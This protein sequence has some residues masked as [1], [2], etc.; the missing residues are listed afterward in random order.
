[1]AITASDWGHSWNPSAR[2]QGFSIDVRV[3]SSVNW[4]KC[5][6]VQGGWR[7][8]QDATGYTV[9][10]TLY[11]SDP[12]P[13][14]RRGDHLPASGQCA[15]SPAFAGY[16][17]SEVEIEPQTSA[18]PWLC[19]VTA[20]PTILS[21]DASGSKRRERSVKLY[22]QNVAVRDAKVLSPDW[23]GMRELPCR[24]SQCTWRRTCST[25]SGVP[26]QHGIVTG[27]PAWTGAGTGLWALREA[28]AEHV[29]DNNG[30]T[31]LRQ[32]T[33]VF[34]QPCGY[35]WKASEFSYVPFSEL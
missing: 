30:T 35:A 11:A 3:A 10:G 21:K 23:T 27:L 31:N 20:K 6:L 32:I 15:V 14:P 28:Q 24:L 1:M 22:V 16:V 19:Q 18:G 5:R 7:Y 13:F 29:K 8:S 9:A 33:A 26:P 34:Y 25:A 17:V 4:N 12:A 2:M